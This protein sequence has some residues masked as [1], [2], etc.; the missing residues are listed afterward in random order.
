MIPPPSL[1]GF[2]SRVVAQ[3][4]HLFFEELNDASGVP[5][6]LHRYR[7]LCGASPTMYGSTVSDLKDVSLSIGVLEDEFEFNHKKT[8][9]LRC[10]VATQGAPASL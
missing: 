5:Q 7:V 9:G 2:L 1:S 8:C 4:L 10:T 3:M 6:F